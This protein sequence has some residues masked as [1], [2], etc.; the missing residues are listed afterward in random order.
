MQSMESQGS[1][2]LRM[3]HRRTFSV[4]LDNAQPNAAPAPK[5]NARCSVQIGSPILKGSAHRPSQVLHRLLGMSSPSSLQLSCVAHG[6]KHQLL[7]QPMRGPL[8][9]HQCVKCCID[10]VVHLP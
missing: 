3:T 5:P 9:P 8:V 4:D 2:G 10:E 6:D 7:N 1:A